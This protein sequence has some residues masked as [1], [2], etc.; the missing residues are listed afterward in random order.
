MKEKHNFK[1]NE[2]WFYLL[3]KWMRVVWYDSYAYIPCPSDPSHTLW[4]LSSPTYV[5]ALWCPISYNHDISFPGVYVKGKGFMPTR[6]RNPFWHCM[7]ARLMFVCRRHVL[8]FEPCDGAALCCTG[9]VCAPDNEWL[10][11]QGEQTLSEWIKQIELTKHT[12]ISRSVSCDGV[13][14]SHQ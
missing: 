9:S 1:K 2:P 8:P 11:I 5:L 7:S 3:Q 13:L 4:N 10:S 6:H 12:V 14:K